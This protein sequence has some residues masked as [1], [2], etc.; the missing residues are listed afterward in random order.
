MR[1]ITLLTVCS[2]LMSLGGIVASQLLFSKLFF[3]SCSVA[4]SGPSLCDPM[5]PC[6]SLSP[7]VCSNSC[8]L[9]RRCH[10]TL[11][12]SVAPFSSCSQNFYGGPA[13][14]QMIA[15]WLLH[16]FIYTFPSL[17]FLSKSPIS[18]KLYSLPPPKSTS[19]V[20]THLEINT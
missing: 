5:N 10:P 15:F 18:W 17:F 6:P 8:P 11:S 7:G 4:Q 13:M 12:S 2:I 9:S 1:C 3:S 20:F 16:S 19:N 14:G